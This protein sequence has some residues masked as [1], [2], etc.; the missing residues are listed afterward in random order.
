MAA[1]ALML[2]G[3]CHR[4]QVG[5]QTLAVVNGA[6]ITRDDVD[7]ELSLLPPDERAGARPRVLPDLI[8][9]KLFAQDAEA[10]GEQRSVTFVRL[11]RR[12]HEAL[13]ARLT[14]DLIVAR[15][16]PGTDAAAIARHRAALRAGATIEVSPGP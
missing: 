7:L 4:V 10:R 14:A 15:A 3:G 1:L 12:W 6:P 16:K 13:L 9:R 8:D 2:G 5:G 11:D